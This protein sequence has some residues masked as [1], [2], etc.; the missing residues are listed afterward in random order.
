MSYVKGKVKVRVYSLISSLKIHHPTLHFYPL[1][2]GPVHL[3][4]IST[5]RRAYS[6]AAVS[7]HWTYTLPSL[8]YQVLIFTWAKWSIWG[9]SALLN[10]A[11]LKQ[12]TNIKRGETWYFSESRILL[13]CIRT[14]IYSIQFS[15]CSKPQCSYYAFPLNF[16]VTPLFFHIVPLI[17]CSTLFIV[18]SPSN[19]LFILLNY[20]LVTVTPFN[21]SATSLNFSITP[22]SSSLFIITQFYF[23]LLYLVSLVGSKRSNNSVCEF[24]V[25]FIVYVYS[26]ALY[27]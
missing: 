20:C 1:V 6:P 16:P 10:E 24:F 17:W 22:L 23:L 18:T 26:I 19:F 5:P 14:T 4:A 13:I 21:F 15:C 2:T 12:C 11:I 3:C 9:L 27:H 8:S 7:A 25:V